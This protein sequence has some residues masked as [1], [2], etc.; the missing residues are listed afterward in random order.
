M[1]FPTTREMFIPKGATKVQDKSSSAV[2]YISTD[3]AGRPSAVMFNGKAV[4]P[5]RNCYYR[6]EPS[7]ERHVREFF[8]NVR[9]AETLIA[10]RKAER[11]EALAQPHKLTVGHILVASWGYEQTNVDY[12]QVTALKGARTVEL[13]KIGCVSNEDLHMQGTSTPRLDAFTGE[14]FTRRVDERNSV[15]LTSYSWAHLWDGRPRRW[16][17]YA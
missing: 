16:T 5:A 14:A 13:R 12:Y 3:R 6:N 7:R 9:Q 17:A 15:K 2:A 1:R 4:K 10:S 11:A 8:D